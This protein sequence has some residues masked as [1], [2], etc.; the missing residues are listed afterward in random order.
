MAYVAPNSTV[1]FFRDLGLNNNYDDSLYFA[2]TAEKDAYFDTVSKIAIGTALTYN[3]EQRGFVRVELSMASLISTAY[4]RFKNTSFENKWFYAFVK[5]VEYINNNCTQVNFEIDPLMTWM[6]DFKL[7]QCFIERQHTITDS[8]GQYTEPE[9]FELGDYVDEDTI[10]TGYFDEYAIMVWRTRKDDDPG[11]GYYSGLYSG[12]FGDV[13]VTPASADST[14]GGLVNTNRSD[15]LVGV[16]MLPKRWAARRDDS[17][18]TEDIISITKPYTNVSG[19]LPHNNKLFTYPYKILVVENSEGD[20]AEYKYEYFGSIPPTVSQGT[21]TFSLYGTVTPTSEIICIP[22]NYNNVNGANYERSIS[23]K[24]FP[25]CAVSIDGYKAYMAQ[26]MSN[27][28][29]TLVSTAFKG[30]LGG[31][32]MTM[33][34]MAA[35]AA[36]GERAARRAIAG[37]AIAQ[38]MDIANLLAQ[39]TKRDTTPDIAKGSASIDAMTA[40][41]A[42]DF[43]FRKKSITSK[44]AEMIDDYF[45]MFGYAIKKIGIPNMNAR[46]YFTY[47]KTVGCSIDGAIPAD[48]ASIIENIFNKGIRFWKNHNNIGNYSL[49]NSPT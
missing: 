36:I 34:G 37:A 15:E 41:R 5:S 40:I 27:L 12:V 39:Q 46:P 22:N 38:D 47:V 10:R 26:L 25:Q 33:P 4:M 19:Y 23:M 14:I 24:H 44:Y 8:I 45:T 18:P 9:N 42:K 48:D 21:C 32:A 31:L 20:S 2:S 30:A 11:G 29:A 49:N 17:E 43:Y 6:G 35:K 13:S 3:R 7:N 1:E 16:T 28:P